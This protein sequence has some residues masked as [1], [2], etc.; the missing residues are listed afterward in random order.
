MKRTIVYTVYKV[1][2][3]QFLQIVFRFHL[4]KGSG[5]NTKRSSAGAG[6]V[7]NN[8]KCIPFGPVVRCFPLDRKK[9]G[10]TALRSGLDC[11]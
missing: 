11:R 7:D 2:Q 10:G 8:K 1:R 4:D 9:G 3:P 5:S 6:G